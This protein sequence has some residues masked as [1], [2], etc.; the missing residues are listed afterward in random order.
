[1]VWNGYDPWRRSSILGLISVTRFPNGSKSR[2]PAG[3]DDPGPG[4]PKDSTS[5]ASPRFPP[6]EFQLILVLSLDK[7]EP[8]DTG[9]CY[10]RRGGR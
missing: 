6:L 2:E 7:M 10:P 4:S 9:G 1:M 3:W 5:S 8:E